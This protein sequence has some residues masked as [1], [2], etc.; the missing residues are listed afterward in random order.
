MPQPSLRRAARMDGLGIRILRAMR[1]STGEAPLALHD[2]GA[3]VT[4]DAARHRSV[5]FLLGTHRLLVD[6][7]YLAPMANKCLPPRM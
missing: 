4:G 2:S 3:P 7:S 5:V 6:S 1:N